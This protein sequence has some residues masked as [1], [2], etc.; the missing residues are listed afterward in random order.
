MQA[1][2]A[3]FRLD[4]LVVHNHSTLFYSVSLN[5]PTDAR[6]LKNVIPKA[7]VVATGL[8]HVYV[9]ANRPVTAKDEPEQQVLQK[10]FPLREKSFPTEESV[11]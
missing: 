8:Y 1:N 5:F 9:A 11:R 7:I 10:S 2:C 6:T 3:H 4:A